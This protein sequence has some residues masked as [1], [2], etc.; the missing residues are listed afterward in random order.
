MLLEPALRARLERLALVSRR[1]IRGMWSG[2]H[3]SVRL[4][5]SLDFADYREYTPGDDF[6]R[7]DHQLWARLGVILVRRYQAEEELTLR[8]VID[9]SASMGYEEKL[10]TARRLAA[11]VGYLALAGGDRVQPICLGGAGSSR[12]VIGPLGRHLSSWPQIERW[13]E[14]IEPGGAAALEEAA[15]RSGSP[16]AA[17]ALTVLVSDL[18]DPGW[19]SAIDKLGATGGGLVLQVLGG[20]EL[21]PALVGDLDLIDGETGVRLP[22]SASVEALDGYQHRLEE[23]LAAVAGRARRS[24]MDHLVVR[25]EAGAEEAA[26]RQLAGAGVLR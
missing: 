2:R 17:R 13:L 10:E 22:F 16:G 11:M 19:E 3:S 15:I 26:L 6:R 21:D 9:A 5:E 12:S 8:L 14:R 7:I 20:G 25:A 4:G 24:G 1:R 18:L 23:F